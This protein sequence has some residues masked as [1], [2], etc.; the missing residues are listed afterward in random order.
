MSILKSS[1]PALILEIIKLCIIVFVN[2]Y[3]G[4]NLLNNSTFITSSIVIGSM[5]IYLVIAYVFQLRRAI[6]LE[7]KMSNQVTKTEDTRIV[8]TSQEKDRTIKIEVSLRRRLSL[9]WRLALWIY[10]NKKIYLKV[11]TNSEE[12]VLTAS[13]RV[14]RI[15]INE[16]MEGFTIDCTD[17]FIKNLITNQDFPHKRQYEFVVN[18]KRGIDVTPVRCFTI[19]TEILLNKRKAG[20]IFD[21]LFNVKNDIHKVEIFP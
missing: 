14:H 18:V 2:F 8:E 1:F 20:V 19:H 16:I 6:H 12:I 13:K 3:A 10:R 9:L 17:L 7:L 5:L 11:Y 15:E 21:S 4:S